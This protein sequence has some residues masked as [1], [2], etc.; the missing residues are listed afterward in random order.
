MPI[1]PGDLQ[2]GLVGVAGP[3]TQASRA[4]NAADVTVKRI[5]QA[6]A[7]VQITQLSWIPTEGD[8]ASHATNVHTVDVLD[9]GVAGAGAV[10]L[11]SVAFTASVASTV[12]TNVT[13]TPAVTLDAGDFLNVKFAT[14]ATASSTGKLFA[15]EY[16]VHYKYV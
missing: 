12:P 9:G 11:A 1:G 3:F 15:G 13:T 7:S 5:W 2:G 6:P 8:Q 4:S 16:F 14:S 10:S